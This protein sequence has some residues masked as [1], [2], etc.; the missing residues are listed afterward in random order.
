MFLNS[1]HKKEIIGIDLQIPEHLDR[2]TQ[3]KPN[4][5]FLIG[6]SVMQFPTVQRFVKG[7]RCMVIIDSL[8]THK[9]VLSEL[10]SYSQLVG[11]GCYMVV[12]D[13]LVDDERYHEDGT[14]RERPWG[15]GNSPR[16]ALNAFLKNNSNFERD[17][18]IRNKLL[19]SC[20]P[21]GYIYKK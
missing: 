17:T 1:F 14:A 8:H 13:T 12:C 7:K 10:N 3:Y 18:E 9:H 5:K 6:D 15:P 16:S 21:D 20:Q 11:S 19:F 2:A 4:I